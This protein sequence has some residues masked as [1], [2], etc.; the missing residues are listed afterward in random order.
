[1]RIDS[2]FLKE[3]RIIAAQNDMTM[4][5]FVDRAIRKEIEELK[6]RK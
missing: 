5:E 4:T 6:K 3:L 2:K 1:M